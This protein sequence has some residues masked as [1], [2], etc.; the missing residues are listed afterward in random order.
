MTPQQK[1]EYIVTTFRGLKPLAGHSI[2]K[3]NCF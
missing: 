3:M 1:K 2:K